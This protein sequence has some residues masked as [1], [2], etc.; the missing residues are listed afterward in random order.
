MTISIKL[1]TQ[2]KQS[3]RLGLSFAIL[4]FSSI[5]FADAPINVDALPKPTLSNYPVN[6]L[7]HLNQQGFVDMP[8]YNALENIKYRRALLSYGMRY[9]GSSAATKDFSCGDLGLI[10]ALWQSAIGSPITGK[11]SYAD[12]TAFARAVDGMGS[13]YTQ[14]RPVYQP[15]TQSRMSGADIEVEMYRRLAEGG[16][17]KAQFRLGAVYEKRQNY[18]EAAK[19]YQLSA[20]QD[21]PLGI[22]AL[23]SLKQKSNSSIS[24][25]ESIS[26][27]SNA[28]NDNSNSDPELAAIFYM[29]KAISALKIASNGERM[30]EVMIPVNDAAI[31]NLKAHFKI[32]E[33]MKRKR[34]IALEIAQAAY[35]C[36]EPDYKDLPHDNE[37][38]LKNIEFLSTYHEQVIMY[39]ELDISGKVNQAKAQKALKM[40]QSC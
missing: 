28:S 30:A 29:K 31:A 10:A 14:A 16:D 2:A 9:A 40:W 17:A 6:G 23:N 4:A 11:F 18:Q 12:A 32:E 35:L 25:T 34:S 15:Q 19:W 3:L 36:T 26:N 8:A 22:N 21:E 20:N 13:A 39:L 7:C 24:Q 5:G 27:S 1:I 33:A 37:K 38:F